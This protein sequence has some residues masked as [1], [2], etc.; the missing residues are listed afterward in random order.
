MAFISWL[1][2]EKDR[3]ENRCIFFTRVVIDVCSEFGVVAE[4]LSVTLELFNAIMA[5]QIQEGRSPQIA[6]G[7]WFAPAFDPGAWGVGVDPSKPLSG[8]GWNG[9]LVAHVEGEQRFIM[10]LSQGQ[11]SRPEYGMNYGPA[12]LEIEAE[13]SPPWSWTLPSGDHLT[14]TPCPQNNRWMTTPA[15]KLSPA[16]RRAVKQLINGTRI[17]LKHFVR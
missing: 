15:W 16:G 5:R 8:P 9:H 7:M 11:F 3:R 4:P 14:I 10:D 1:R 6:S 17:E 12:L 2:L 13:T